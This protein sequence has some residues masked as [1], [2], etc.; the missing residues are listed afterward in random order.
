MVALKNILQ[1]NRYNRCISAMKSNR[2]MVFDTQKTN[3]K[4]FIKDI[5]LSMFT[6]LGRK[7]DKEFN[8]PDNEIFSKLPILFDS[9]YL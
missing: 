2:L 5:D 6:I 3:F 8:V 1:N 4:E 7:W 9:Y